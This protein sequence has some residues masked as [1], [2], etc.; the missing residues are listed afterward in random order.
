[1]GGE[2]FHAHA[3]FE[4][5]VEV[6]AGRG[7]QYG[8]QIAAMDR[9]VGCAVTRRCKRAERHAQDF[10]SVLAVEHAETFRHNDQRCEPS[11]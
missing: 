4:S 2:I 8:L 1:V 5:D 11:T 10:A 3:K 6:F 7:G 9:P